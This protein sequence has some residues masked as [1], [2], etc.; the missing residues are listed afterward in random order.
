MINTFQNLLFRI[1]KEPL[2]HGKSGSFG[3]PN[4]RFCNAK[5]KLSFSFRIIFTKLKLFFCISLEQRRGNKP[6]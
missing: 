3:V 4:L 5:T 6:C 2:L 1:V